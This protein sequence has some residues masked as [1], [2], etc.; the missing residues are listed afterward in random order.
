MNTA[1]SKKKLELWYPVKPYIV[2]QGFGVNGDYYQRNGVNIIG[3]NGLDLAAANGQLCRAA[4]DGVVVFTGEDGKGGLGVVVRTTEPYDYQGDAVYFKTIYWHL[5]PNSF[6][7]KPG[8][9]VKV[10]DVLA[11]CD[12]TGLAT[13]PHLHFGLKPVAKKGEE[14]WAWYNIEQNNGYLGAI[15]PT[16]YFNGYYAEDSQKVLATLQ[17]ILDLAR[18]AVELLKRQVGQK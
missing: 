18:R 3:H 16:P 14:D 9:L 7:V 13:G 12:T 8:Q 11:E 4:H 2:T 1:E 15:D 5:K 10:G 17:T 6:K